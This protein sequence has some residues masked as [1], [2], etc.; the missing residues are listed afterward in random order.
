[1]PR[2]LINTKQIY[3]KDRQTWRNWLEQNHSLSSGIWVVYDK[4][5]DGK[6]PLSYDDLVEEVLCFGWIDS[7]P[8]AR[9]QTQTSHYV[10]PRK[11]KSPWSRLNKQRIEKLIDTNLMRESGMKLIQQAQQ[12]GSWSVYD[13][14]VNMEVPDDLEKALSS[15]KQAKTHFYAFTPSVL[16]PLIWH[17]MCAKRPETRAKRIEQIVSAAE[18]NENPLEF[19]RK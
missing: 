2:P 4:K 13:P 17:V 18:R 16:K 10:C 7:L 6:Q 8:R 3:M 9:N 11:P 1:M 14:V 19:K 12:D 5:K 15:N